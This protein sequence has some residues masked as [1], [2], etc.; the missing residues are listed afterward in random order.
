M[1][2]APVSQISMVY[3]LM[4]ASWAVS[5]A[6]SSSNHAIAQAFQL[7]RSGIADAAVTGGAESVLCFG[8]MKAWEGLRAMSPDGCRPFSKNRN[9]M[10][11][12]EGAPILVLEEFERARTHGA[13]I[14][15]EIVGAG[16]TAD[17]G[18]IVAPAVDGAARAM[19]QAL[20]DAGMAPGQVDYI[21]AHGTATTINDRAE[22]AAIHMVL[23][24]Q[25]KSVL[26]S[27]TKS[28]HGHCIGATGA[29]EAAA[30]LLALG[31]GVVAPTINHDAPD[32]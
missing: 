14:P 28:M 15:G 10:V 5:T 31:E 2:N 18:G 9:G 17:A 20:S 23:G 19:R 6:C 32:P 13:P 11:L 7:V 4:G 27:A 1:A 16:M 22:A 26:V 8:G 24:E 30:T 12:G 25:A 29:V 21:N 3:G